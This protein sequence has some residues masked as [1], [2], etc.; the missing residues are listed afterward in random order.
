MMLFF[1]N[2][3]ASGLALYYFI[4][5]ITSIGQMWVI[6]KYFIDEAAIREKI[7]G[8]KK[9]PKSK[10]NFMQRLEDAQKAQRAKLEQVK[11][12]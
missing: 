12:K 7:D 1:F 6:K 9:K 10:S 2:N 4:A 11:K 3:Q 8:N 5:N